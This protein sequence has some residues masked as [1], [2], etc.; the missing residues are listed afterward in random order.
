[1]II[2]SEGYLSLVEYLT[3]HLA[4]FEA[5]EDENPG[6]ATLKQFIRYQLAEQMFLI[7][8]RH[9]GL[10]ADDKIYIVD[11]FEQ[12]FSDLSEVLGRLLDHKATKAQR[13]FITDYV[14]LVKNLFDSQF[15]GI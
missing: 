5:E 9:K 13:T 12:V 4:L 6:T 10:N 11:D 2:Q 14:S 7:F 8:S 3:E 15:E 1:M